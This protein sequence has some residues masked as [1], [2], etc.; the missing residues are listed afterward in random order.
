[1]SLYDIGKRIIDIFGAIVGIV[2][3]SPILLGAAIW[4][5]V[6]SPEGPV[7]ADIKNRVGKDK[8][9]FKL[10][11]FRSMV[12]NGY[13]Y[14]K[15]NYPELH[16]K[17]EENNYKLEADEDPRLIKGAK[18]FRKYSID[19]LPQFFNVLAGNMSIVGPRAYY[20]YEIDEQLA[21]HPEEEQYMKKALTVKPGITGLWQVSGRSQL[22]F[23]NRVKLD[24]EYAEKKSLVYD[25][26]IIL[27]TPYVVITGKGA[28]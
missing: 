24:A 14:L 9:P 12:P 19:E 4:V 6:V 15:K 1:M 17:Y 5:K 22:G 26:K 13:D 23:V 28:F 10:L 18:L 25:L 27:K 7:F 11:K 16:K 2:L 21:R 8:K 20:F 3:F